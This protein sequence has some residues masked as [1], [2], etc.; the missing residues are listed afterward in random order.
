[1]TVFFLVSEVVP[2]GFEA[3]ETNLRRLRSL[4]NLSGEAV[5]GSSRLFNLSTKEIGPSLFPSREMVSVYGGAAA[6]VRSANARR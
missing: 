1:M 6:A 3:A 4:L 2:L 5:L